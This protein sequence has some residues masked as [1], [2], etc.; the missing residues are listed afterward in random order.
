M[1]SIALTDQAFTIEGNFACTKTEFA[2]SKIQRV[3]I[4]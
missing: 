2:I 4:S 1:I 3:S